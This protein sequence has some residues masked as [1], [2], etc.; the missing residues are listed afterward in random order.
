MVPPPKHSNKC[1]ASS[2]DEFSEKGFNIKQFWLLFLW[3]LRR[4]FVDTKY[5]LLVIA[6]LY[7]ATRTAVEQL[8]YCWCD[9]PQVCVVEWLNVKWRLNYTWIEAIWQNMI[10]LENLKSNWNGDV[11][12]PSY[13]CFQ[14]VTEFVT[15]VYT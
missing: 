6:L 10:V 3:T 12:I 1:S 5:Q 13:D 11:F 4:L 8:D 9:S 15:H 14:N 7:E 2:F